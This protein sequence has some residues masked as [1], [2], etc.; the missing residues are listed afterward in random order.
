MR[1]TVEDPAFADGLVAKGVPREFVSVGGEDVAMAS[2]TKTA[3][4]AER[5]R[6]LLTAG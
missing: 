2:A 4:L 5:Y 6:S 1:E 3:E